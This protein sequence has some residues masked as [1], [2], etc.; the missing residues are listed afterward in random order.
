[1]FRGE[2]IT[3]GERKSAD[4]HRFLLNRATELTDLGGMEMEQLVD[5]QSHGYVHCALKSDASY[6]DGER[7]DWLAGV[8]VAQG[9][10]QPHQL[11]GHRRIGGDSIGNLFEGG[12]R[13][14]G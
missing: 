6:G 13:I 8:T 7:G 9:L 2:F 14:A 10:C 3:Q 1:M 11:T 4:M 12:A 5:C